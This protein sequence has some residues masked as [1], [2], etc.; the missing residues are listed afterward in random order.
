MLYKKSL[1]KLDMDK[2]TNDTKMNRAKIFLDNTADRFCFQIVTESAKGNTTL[3]LIIESSE[4]ACPL[5]AGPGVA[6]SSG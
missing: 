2:K 1:V 4:D 5:F 3:N 6:G